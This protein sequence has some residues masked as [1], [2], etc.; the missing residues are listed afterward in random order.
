MGEQ[1]ERSKQIDPG[2]FALFGAWFLI[3]IQSFGGGATTLLLIQ[4]SVVERHGWF[5]DEAYTRDFA[6]SQITPGINILALT[7]LLGWR[8]RGLAGG[9][10]ALVGLLLPSVTITLG[11]TAGYAQVRTLAVVQTALHGAIPAT[12]GLSL[13]LAASMARPFL[14]E[15]YQ[16]SHSMLLFS[17]ALLVGS[18]LLMGLWNVPVVVVLL[19]AGLVSGL[20]F[21]FTLPESREGPAA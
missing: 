4:R 9:F 17:V 16:M 21:W 18:S 10:T 13:V 12:V 11:L 6:I 2:L 15:S 1:Q 5:S 3:G 7:L 8:L 19:G 14:R 20:V